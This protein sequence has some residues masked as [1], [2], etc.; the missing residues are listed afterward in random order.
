MLPQGKS[1]NSVETRTKQ[2]GEILIDFEWARHQV[3]PFLHK[4]QSW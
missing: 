3:V 2:V 1:G 4:E